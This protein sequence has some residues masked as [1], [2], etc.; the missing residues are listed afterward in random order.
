MI[1]IALIKLLDH[2]EELSDFG[3]E[4]PDQDHC[5]SWDEFDKLVILPDRLF[6]MIFDFI[7]NMIYL[8]SIT[9]S[10]FLIAFHMMTFDSMYHLEI[11]IDV[12]VIIDMILYFFTAY[13][14]SDGESNDRY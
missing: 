8:V 3:D 4:A 9:T 12:I 7:V 5:L 2:Q 6:K 13:E 10:S 1:Q 14:G 11:T